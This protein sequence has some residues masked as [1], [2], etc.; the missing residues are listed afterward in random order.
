M[1][2][3]GHPAGRGQGPSM[4]DALLMMCESPMQIGGQDLKVGIYAGGGGGQAT[5]SKGGWMASLEHWHT[6]LLFYTNK[7]HVAEVNNEM[8]REG[9]R[10]LATKAFL[11]TAHTVKCAENVQIAKEFSSR[12][13][14]RPQ[15]FR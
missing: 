13:L 9:A 14:S 2:G 8:L 12:I 15:L 6:H 1:R 4:G 10:E 3:Q 7:C 5:P 11:T